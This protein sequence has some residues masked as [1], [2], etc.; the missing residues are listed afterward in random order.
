MAIYSRR[1]DELYF[2]LL[3]Q[4]KNRY[5]KGHGIENKTVKNLYGFVFNK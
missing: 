3:I 1:L 4:N 2:L 5:A